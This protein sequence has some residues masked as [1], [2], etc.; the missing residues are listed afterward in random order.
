MVFKLYGDLVREL[1]LVIHLRLILSVDIDCVSIVY[2]RHIGD[3]SLLRWSHGDR[4]GPGRRALLKL[5]FRVCLALH[6][7]NVY[8]ASI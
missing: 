7:V 3:R 4:A 8:V 6:L 1:L 2:I 5:S